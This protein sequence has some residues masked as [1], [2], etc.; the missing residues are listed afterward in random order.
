MKID[1]IKNDKFHQE[2]AINHIFIPDNWNVVE[3]GTKNIEYVTDHKEVY[4]LVKI[5]L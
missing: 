5:K 2:S 3:M 1:E 4:T